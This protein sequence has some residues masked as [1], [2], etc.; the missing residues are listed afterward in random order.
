MGPRRSLLQRADGRAWY[1]WMR[2][3]EIAL[4]GGHRSHAVPQPVHFLKTPDG[5]RLAWTREEQAARS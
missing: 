5:I 2:L 1:C 4:G 3:A